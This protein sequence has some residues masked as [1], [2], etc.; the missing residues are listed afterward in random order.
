MPEVEIL[1]KITRVLQATSNKIG[2]T[3]QS[4]INSDNEWNYMSIYVCN[5]TTNVLM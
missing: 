4:K 2:A 1:S 5:K 3:G